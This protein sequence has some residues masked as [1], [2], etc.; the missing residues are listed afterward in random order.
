M[1]ADVMPDS[2]RWFRQQTG[3]CEALIPQAPRGKRAHMVKA[4]AE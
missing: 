3:D 4:A 2:T 1:P